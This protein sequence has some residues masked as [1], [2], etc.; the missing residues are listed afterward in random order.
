MADCKCVAATE[1]L[2]VK[3][4]VCCYCKHPLKTE[5]ELIKRTGPECNIKNDKYTHYICE[6]CKDI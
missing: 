1:L 2:A 6:P 3:D 5:G 4:R